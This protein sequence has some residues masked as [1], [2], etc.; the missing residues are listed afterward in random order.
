MGN[1]SHKLDDRHECRVDAG[2][3][4]ITRNGRPFISGPGY[5]ARHSYPGGREKLT[6]IVVGRIG[7]RAPDDVLSAIDKELKV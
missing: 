6:E 5:V 3:V 1:R 7:F 4:T 2:I